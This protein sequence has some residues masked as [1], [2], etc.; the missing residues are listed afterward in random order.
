M[1][2]ALAQ[3]NSYDIRWRW[4]WVVW[5]IVVMG[6]IL[7]VSLVWWAQESGAWEQVRH[8]HRPHRPHAWSR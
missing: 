4:V 8:R 6:S 7:A 5:S 1:W 2:S 3:A